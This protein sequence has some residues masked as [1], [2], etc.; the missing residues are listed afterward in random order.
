VTPTS[1]KPRLLALNPANIPV[2]LRAIPAWIGWKLVFERKRWSKKPVDI[3][4]GGLAETD[5]PHTWTDFETALRNYERLG[6]DGIGLSRTDDYV[7]VDLDGVLDA[8]GK[9]LPFPWGARILHTLQ[10]RAYLERSITGTGIHG[11]G[12]GTLPTGRRQWDDPTREHTGYALYD[13]SRYFTF[14]G[15]VF[16]DSAAMNDFDAGVSQSL[17]RVVNAAGTGEWRPPPSSADRLENL[18][19][20]LA[21]ER[22]HYRVRAARVPALA[23][24]D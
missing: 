24:V 21:G 22:P 23:S 1:P 4:S 20:N 2:E 5:N 9:L 19:V 8:D 13:K 11:V 15:H 10:G 12:R 18:P 16:P 17:S 6:C 14:S 7:F 3:N